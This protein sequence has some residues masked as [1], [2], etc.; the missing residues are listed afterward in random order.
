MIALEY[1]GASKYETEI[2][3]VFRAGV[4][5][6][7]DRRFVPLDDAQLPP[8]SIHPIYCEIQTQ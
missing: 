3:L 1:H 5:V 2:S 6:T 4:N 8:K 7:T